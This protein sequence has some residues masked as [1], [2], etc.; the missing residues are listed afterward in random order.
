MLA[1]AVAFWQVVLAVHIAAVVAA[2]G[3]I[4]AFPLLVVVGARKEP[5]AMPSLHRMR[6]LIGRALVNPGL[7]L[8]VI[9]G[10]YLASDLHQWKHFYVQ[11]GLGVAIVLGGLEGAYV[12][13]RERRLAELAERDLGAGGGE[14]SPEYVALRGRVV[15][16]HAVMIALVLA[17]IYLMTVAA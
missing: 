8:V 3:V 7:L 5:G 12:L 14:L 2:F 4:I 9:A 6:R 17:T 10:I 15:T 13:P 1:T 11:W 16:V